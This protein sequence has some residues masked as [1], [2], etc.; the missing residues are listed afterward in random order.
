[1]AVVGDPG[2]R[3]SL[4]SRAKGLIARGAKTEDGFTLIEVVI[5]VSLLVMLMAPFADAYIS[6]LDATSNSQQKEVA[7]MLADTALDQVRAIDATKTGGS[8]LVYG[9]LAAAVTTE[10]NSPAAG[11]STSTGILSD[12]VAASDPT[13]S[14]SPAT[15][16]T[17]PQTETVGA[18]TYQVYYYV[19]TCWE[20]AYTSGGQNSNT[21]TSY[22]PA[23]P[24]SSGYQ[25]YRVIVDVTWSPPRSG[26]G[27]SGCYYIASSLVNGSTDPA[28]DL[29]PTIP[30]MTSATN[31][32][33]TV[34]TPGSFQVISSGFPPP[35]FKDQSYGSGACTTP[36]PALPPG[37]TLSTTGLLSGTPS[38][39]VGTY[40]V[41][42]Q[43][44]N[45]GGTG[46]QQF[47]LSVVKASPSLSVA[48]STSSGVLGTAI[49]GS[50]ITGTL[51]G[52]YNEG[53]SI[54]FTV[55]GPSA[56][57]ACTTVAASLGSVTA[58]G[59]TA[60]SPTT[61]FTPTAAGNYWVNASYGGDSNNNAAPGTCGSAEITVAMASPTVT[62]TGPANATTGTAISPVT[63]ISSV[64]ASGYN[65][66]GTL[67]VTVF[68]TNIGG[69]APSSCTSGGLVVAT[70][71]VTGNK[72]YNPPTFTPLLPGNYWWYASY[73]G[74]TNNNPAVSTCGASM[75]KTTVTGKASPT[76]I[77]A[78]PA[79]GTVGTVVTAST[80]SAVL[81][82]G[83][84]PTG[85][86]SPTGTISFY[87]VGPQ[88]TA[89]TSNC[90]SGALLGTATVNGNGTYQLSSTNWKPTWAGDYWWYASFADTDTN[91]NNAS[92]TCGAG[93]PE[94]AV[95]VYVVEDATNSGATS[96]VTV[97]PASPT[98]TS[99]QSLVILVYADATSGVPTISSIGGT[100]ISGLPTLV[101]SSSAGGNN[102]VWAYSAVATGTASGTV[103]VAVSGTLQYVRVDVLVL[104]DNNNPLL[105][106]NQTNSKT[107]SGNTSPIATLTNQPAAGDLEVAFIG[108]GGSDGGMGTTPGGWTKADSA[109]GTAYGMAVYYTTT[110]TTTSQAFS[111][112]SS[113]TW[114]VIAL[115]I[116]P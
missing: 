55:Y 103:T 68:D 70:L 16:P 11:L 35:T 95:P 45:A 116:N 79:T 23:S 57:A 48:S 63:L 90:S 20:P 40:T 105:A 104:P 107:S 92:S 97:T 9:R 87:V 100:A 49:P 88:L 112:S 36:T 98:P 115:D 18:G 65:P 29:N 8:K 78:G 4:P 22:N 3:R 82:G 25:M 38:G 43:A 106:Q 33:F 46:T 27:P 12:T 37:V 24:P 7:A 75:S 69:A 21:C 53:G 10:W 42:I 110:N 51:A 32:T 113:V 19:G 102:E 13:T 50:D 62:A 85:T 15:L 47:S 6:S 5:A 108:A 34:G 74:D 1:M 91:N 94:M 41:C 67:T 84:L 109:N 56:T 66:T 54:T 59:N 86:S 44:T 71:A 80:V 93:M 96:P 26:C 76:L 61:A 89:P 83:Y 77:A 81:S 72:T 28:F 114:G 64:L 52:G 39:G 2:F 17:T 31:T 14:D 60:Y 111:F 30:Y 99:G 58:S 101:N 73:T